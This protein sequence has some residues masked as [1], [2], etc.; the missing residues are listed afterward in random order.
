MY[1]AMLF[2]EL[3][4]SII[5]FSM[6]PQREEV[7]WTALFLLFVGLGAFPYIITPDQSEIWQWISLTLNW[8]YL[9]LVPCIV[10]LASITYSNVSTILPLRHIR[11]LLFTP[12][13]L[14]YWLNMLLYEDPYDVRLPTIWITLYYSASVFLVVYSYWRE[15]DLMQRRNR[16]YIM[17]IICP[18]IVGTLSLNYYAEI[19]FPAYELHRLIPLV[20]A[21]SFLTFLIGALYHGV[22]GVRIRLER[23][24][25]GSKVRSFAYGTSLLNHTMKNELDKMKYWTLKSKL[26]IDQKQYE[27]LQSYME[28][29][30]HSQGHLEDMMRRIHNQSQEII[31]KETV[32]DIVELL[33]Q[34]RLSS[35]PYLN[36]RRLTITIDN[37]MTSLPL[38]CD[39]VHMYEVFMNLIKNALDAS[40]DQS[41]DIHL[42]WYRWGNELVIEFQ[43]N[44]TGIA[45][46]DLAH[47][48]EPFY[49]TKRSIDNFG[50]G[51]YYVNAVMQQHNGLLD[52]HSEYGLGTVVRLRF[53]KRRMVEEA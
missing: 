1:W 21:K 7:R 10:L 20:I 17:L 23:Q 38:Q 14:T 8:T 2:I 12:P 36:E 22:F 33:E 40:K 5:V 9:F 46:H 43:D 27:P 24:V 42:H 15:K 51:L 3:F 4:C 11:W 31:L 52:V 18:C 41:C 47:I 50:L 29:I 48:A 13:L 19:W 45:K 49:T 6:N 30:E 34:A 37:K 44:G 16:Q 39:P 26:S 35:L 28:S 53:P 25:I 32:C